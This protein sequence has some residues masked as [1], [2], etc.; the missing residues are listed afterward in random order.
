[1]VIQFLPTL[2]RIGT[3]LG[4]VLLNEVAKPR[5]RRFVQEQIRNLQDVAV[6]KGSTRL[7]GP[8]RRQTFI[9]RRGRQR[10]QCRKVNYKP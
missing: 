1:M 3:Q 8:L 7:K 9:M 6:K 4:P 5:F 2:V 10:F